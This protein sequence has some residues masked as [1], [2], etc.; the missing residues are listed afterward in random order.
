MVRQAIADHPAFDGYR[1][2]IK[3]YTKGSYAN[4][5]NVKNDSDVDIVVECN[6][7]YYYDYEPG[8]ERPVPGLVSYG[9]PWTSEVWRTEVEAALIN[10]FG[11][12]D[13]DTSGRVAIP[14]AERLGSR[15][16]IDVVPS[17]KFKLYR[18]TNHLL[19]PHEGS[20]VRPA[21][22]TPVINWPHHQLGNGRARNIATGQ[23]Y[24]NYVRALKNAENALVSAGTIAEPM[25][26]YL[27]EGLIWNASDTALKHGTLDEGFR[28]TLL[29]LA[30]GLNDSA[31]HQ[32]WYEPN[33]IKPLFHPERKWTLTDARTIVLRTW[34]YLGYA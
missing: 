31:V 30:V 17:F 29:H 18:D 21:T 14:I 12:G 3:V 9:G 4:N 8:V 28:A 33:K 11:A 13:V 1:Q 25:P 32:N 7:A 26:S 23:R 19:T 20:T 34:E 15:P 24:K 22:G 27:M 5:T 10:A 6:H 2:S 16:S